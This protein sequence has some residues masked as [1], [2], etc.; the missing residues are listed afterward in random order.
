MP[1]TLF[2]KN[3][4]SAKHTAASVRFIQAGNAQLY[5]ITNMPTTRNFKTKQINNKHLISFS[6]STVW[7]GRD[8]LIPSQQTLSVTGM[9]LTYIQD[10]SA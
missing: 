3:Q 4:D 8:H 9:R 1:I 6:L 5:H 10:F 2:Q 7:R